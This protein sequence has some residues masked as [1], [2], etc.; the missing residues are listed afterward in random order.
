MIPIPLGTCC[1][2]SVLPSF[3]GRVPCPFSASTRQSFPAPFQLPEVLQPGFQLTLPSPGEPALPRDSGFCQRSRDSVPVEHPLG[4][5]PERGEIPFPQKQAWRAE[6]TPTLP[7]QGECGFLEGLK[8]C[9]RQRVSGVDFWAL[10]DCFVCEAC[11]CHP[12]TDP[13]VNPSKTYRMDFFFLFLLLFYSD[14][15]GELD[16]VL[17]SL[18]LPLLTSLPR[19]AEIYVPHVC[20]VGV[21][22]CFTYWMSEITYQSSW[23][24]SCRAVHTH[25][26]LENVPKPSQPEPLLPLSAAAGTK[27]M[28]HIY[29]TRCQSKTCSCLLLSHPWS[30][31]QCRDLLSA[32]ALSYGMLPCGAVFHIL[33]SIFAQLSQKCWLGADFAMG[34]SQSQLT[35]GFYLALI[36]KGCAGLCHLGELPCSVG[37]SA[38]AGEG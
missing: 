27:R 3:T 2:A 13:Q 29:L 18:S 33:C 37:V 15:Q 38:S 19:G 17:K 31:P 4:A 14:F 21:S 5:Y 11:P 9:H 34:W 35:A 24:P 28:S 26:S 7:G 36:N 6:V 25:T 20:S 32:P 8:V 23:L 22:M 10:A 12:L 16:E 30:K 1:G